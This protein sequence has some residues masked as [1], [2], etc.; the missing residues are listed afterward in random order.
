MT[1]CRVHLT[2]RTVTNQGATM[3]RISAALIAAVLVSAPHASAAELKLI[4][5][6]SVRG[7]I[8]GMVDDYSRQT[9]HTF[10]VTVGTTGQLR[11]IIKSGAP[12]DLI[13]A[14]QDLMGELEKTGKMMPGSRTDLGRVGI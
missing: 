2:R 3:T 8:G 5:A 9:G 1:D 10:K 4:S 7:L 14:S 12:A 11:N 6:G 13:I